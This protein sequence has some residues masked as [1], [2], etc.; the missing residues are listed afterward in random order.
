APFFK[1]DQTDQRDQTDPR[2]KESRAPFYYSNLPILIPCK[3]RSAN[4]QSQG[5]KRVNNFYSQ[6]LEIGNP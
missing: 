5:D 1:I 3:V 2:D 4:K 6:S